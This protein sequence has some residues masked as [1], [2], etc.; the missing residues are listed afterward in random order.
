MLCV[1]CEENQNFNEMLNI[2][3][4]QNVLIKKKI[5]LYNIYFL[6]WLDIKKEA[7]LRLEIILS[8]SFILEW[9]YTMR[10]FTTPWIIPFIM[11]I[12]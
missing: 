10:S 11:C 4:L 9:E 6:I 12:N 3:L 2:F 7:I 1:L 8:F 5:I